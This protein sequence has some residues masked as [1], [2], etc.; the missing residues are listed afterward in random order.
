M[1]SK[2]LAVRCHE[3][4]TGLASKIV[5]DF[6]QLTLVG[7][8]VRLAL[9]IQGLPTI[10]F[11]KL[12]LV[13]SHFL[14]INPLSLR[15]VLDMLAEVEFVKLAT[16]GKTINK[17]VPDVPYYESLYETIGEYAVDAGF[18]ETEQ[19]SI[20]LLRRLAKSPEKL[21][22]L[23]SKVGAEAQRFDRAVLL[24]VNGGYIKKD[25]H[26]GKDLLLSPAY[27]SENSEIFADSVAKSGANSV[28][29]VMEAL[30]A[31]QGIPLSI[32]ENSVKTGNSNLNIDDLAIL[33][34][35]AANGIV[36]PPTIITPHSGENYFM[37]TPTPGNSALAGSR[38]EIYERAMAI[39][40]AVRQGQYLPKMH[41]VRDPAAII[42]RLKNYGKLSRATTEARDQYKN[43]Q[44][45]RIAQLVP[46]GN[47]YAELHVIQSEANNEALEIAYQ[48]VSS[49]AAS[50]IEVDEDARC[51]LQQ[52]QQYV[53][54]LI[55]SAKLKET[56]KAPISEEAAHQLE[57][58]FNK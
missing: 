19:L 22:A 41:A 35:L 57:I 2:E 34:R 25:R 27:F 23:R 21:D 6:E 47:G 42:G 43:L 28:L 38:R 48:L 40:A 33:Q 24:G 3:I 36:R 9:H 32:L 17:V 18:N 46:A 51:A 5:D 58:I 29:K 12:K 4:Q 52:D 56:L 26:R 8:A 30:R 45:L 54:S 16:T 39:V 7:S 10:D 14:D 1:E 20:E 37:F 11:E 55:S 15:P 50:G 13:A 31:N 44:H 53:E 49:G